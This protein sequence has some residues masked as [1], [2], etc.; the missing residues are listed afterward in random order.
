MKNKPQK[1]LV[2]YL[3]L[4]AVYWVFLHMSM[5]KTSNYNFLYSFLF[6]LIPLIGGITGMLKSDI[7]GKLKSSLGKAIFYTSFGLFLW[8]AGSMVWS[9][10]NFVEKIAAPYP[11][12]ADFGFAPSIFFWAVGAV[13]L[14]KASGARFGFKNSHFAKAFTFIVPPLILG[15][16][17]YLLVRVARGG[18]LVPVG[19]TP[20]KLILDI[21]YP[22]G[23]FIALTLASVILG[24][25]FK[26][27]GGYFKPS[28]VSWLAGLAVM[29]FAD[30]AFSYTTTNATFFNGSWVDGLLTVGLFLMTFGILGFATK[31]KLMSKS[32]VLEASVEAGA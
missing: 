5:L 9:Y 2:A 13:Y 30:F 4:L 25:S 31:P 14:S 1:L 20:L 23:D 7:W 17:Y 29:Y 15:A 10:Y 6:S 18:V 27:F 26:Y 8:G 32:T 12:L 21:A 3:G 24:L 11:S 28:I 19:E 22:F 16:S